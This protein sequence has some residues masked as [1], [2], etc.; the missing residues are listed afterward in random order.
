MAFGVGSLWV[1]LYGVV[2]D[3]AGEAQGVPIVFWLMAG[4]FILAA[5]GTVPIQ[6]DQ[7]A[8][9]NADHEASLID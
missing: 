4:A 1:A 2:I 5:L 8:R 9:S 7:R 6:A 3:L